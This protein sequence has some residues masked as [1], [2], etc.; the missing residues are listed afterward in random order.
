VTTEDHGQAVT[1]ER[2]A[3]SNPPISPHY[4]PLEWDRDVDH[5]DGDDSIEARG[6]DWQYTISPV[7]GSDQEVIGFRVSG[8]DYETGDE[9]GSSLIGGRVGELTLA[10]AKAA[11]DADYAS[12]YRE[13]EQ[14][15]DDLLDD[16]DDDDYRPRTRRNDSGRIV[17]RVDSPD[18]EEV[19]VVATLG[20]SKYNVGGLS[21]AL[22]LRTIL[23]YTYSGDRDGLLDEM[24]R[25]IRIATRDDRP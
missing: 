17:C 14:F 21:L 3:A 6:D 20:D 19:E 12:R 7:C 24:H 22:S 9:F 1:S 5:L 18:V 15:L 8:G 16:W 23:S 4:A 10:K 13:A 11:A 25:L 2:L